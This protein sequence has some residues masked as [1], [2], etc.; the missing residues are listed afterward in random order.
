[1]ANIAS[2]RREYTVR[3]NLVPKGYQQITNLS[4]AV[5][6]TVPDEARVAILQTETQD[7]RWRD[8]G[9]DPTDSIGMVLSKDSK[10]ESF[11]Y[12]GDLS[13]IK[14]IAATGNPVLNVS[15]YG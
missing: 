8:D 10:E 2:F 14:F 3:G 6:L 7:I 13:A 1:M 12:A 5:G 11:M 4:S 9:T 15:Y